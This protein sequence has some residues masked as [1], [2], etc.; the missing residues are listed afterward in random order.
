MSNIVT[1][2]S[3]FTITWQYATRPSGSP[4]N[5]SEWTT[6]GTSSNVLY[7]SLD[8]PLTTLY[9]TVVHTACAK[10]GATDADTEVS[11]LWDTFKGRNVTNWTGAPLYYYQPGYN[12][13]SNATNFVDFLQLKRGDCGV[14]QEFFESCLQVHAIGSAYTIVTPSLAQYPDMGFIMRKW[15][16]LN[17]SR[18]QPYA[19]RMNFSETNMDMVPVRSGGIYGEL[20]TEPG[21]AGQGSQS[22]SQRVFQVHKIN[23]V[24]ET[25]YDPSY[26]N[27]YTNENDMEAFLDGYYT[28]KVNGVNSSTVDRRQK[29]S[30]GLRF[31]K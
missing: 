14:W 4:P 24:G 21:I 8:Q 1:T 5:W 23:Y 18:P 26:G 12:F 6:F 28:N 22:P 10:A 9:R 31:V 27:L 29:G 25:Y 17:G 13:R 16:E 2:Y 11:N 3:S 30:G 20:S 15:S 19:W 7:V